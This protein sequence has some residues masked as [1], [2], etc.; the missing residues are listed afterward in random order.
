MSGENYRRASR[1]QATILADRLMGYY[2]AIQASDPRVF[3]TGM[4]ELLSSYPQLVAERAVNAVNGFPS[5]FKFFP[6]IAEA[7]EVL[8]EWAQEH[9]WQRDL[10]ERFARSVMPAIEGPPRR[11][12]KDELCERYGIRDFPRGW[13]AVDLAKLKHKHGDRFAEYVE[14]AMKSNAPIP[15]SA[16][17]KIVDQA[18]EAMEAN[19]AQRDAAE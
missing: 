6:S 9:H 16:F 19:Q 18:R 15:K 4:I 2:P 8:E 3:L 13:D 14:A 5:R 1:E 7:K 12:Y 11:S 10:R 17:E